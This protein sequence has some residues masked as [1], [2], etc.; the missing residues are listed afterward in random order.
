MS[1][2]FAL[3]RDGLHNPDYQIRGGR[4]VISVAAGAARDRL[5][6]ALS[7]QLREWYLDVSRG[8]PYYGEGGILG[9]KMSEGEVAAILRRRILL[10]AEVE[11]VEEFRMSQDPGRRVSVSADVLLRLLDG[12]SETIN[13]E[14]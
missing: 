10:T 9:G 2:S 5:F 4:I 11:R 1:F 13:I 7:T 14:V 6:T 3:L 12:S 8:V